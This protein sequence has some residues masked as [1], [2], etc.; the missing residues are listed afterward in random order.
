MKLRFAGVYI[1]IFLLTLFIPSFAR[2]QFAI[3]SPQNWEVIQ[4]NSTHEGQ[5]HLDIVELP[6][7]S[8]LEYLVLNVPQSGES[9]HVIIR[10]FFEATEGQFHTVLSL[11]SGGWYELQIIAR[12]AA[13][14]EIDRRV[15]RRFGVGEIYLSAGQ[16]N[17][18]NAGDPFPFTSDSVSTFDPWIGLWQQARN[19]MPVGNGFGGSIWPYFG[20]LMS[21]RLHVPVAVISV[22]CGGTSL[23]Q[24]LPN[25]PPVTMCSSPQNGN[26]FE[27]LKFTLK[28]LRTRGGVRAI[29][30]HQGETDAAMGTS[31]K[32]YVDEFAEVVKAL[33]AD[34]TAP[35]NWFVAHATYF[36]DLKGG[37]P[38]SCEGLSLS[39][40]SMRKQQVIR[41]AQERIW[42]LGLAHPGPDTDQWIGEEFRS[43][44]QYCIHFNA[45]GQKIHAEGWAAQLSRW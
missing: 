33:N 4:Q 1:A 41:A 15:V 8:A 29:L 6:R 27:R 9:Q 35:L 24:W 30:W 37:V 2:A 3:R 11:P 34:E 19:P 25:A 28:T 18:V 17:S 36:P 43:P 26:L 7:A 5:V 45:Y 32:A 31:A 44:S 13:G 16:S 22:G 38:R 39:L 20:D 21:R 12:D 10:N 42:K 23:A 40:E 14:A